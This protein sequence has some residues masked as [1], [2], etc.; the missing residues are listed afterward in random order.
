M[1]RVITSS[2]APGTVLA[3]DPPAQTVVDKGATVSLT[4]AK[5]RPAVPDVTTGN[6]SVADA[7]KTLEDAGYKVD[8]RD[9]ANA[10]P[11]RPSDNSGCAASRKA[12]PMV[13]VPMLP[14]PV[15]VFV[16]PPAAKPLPAQ[17]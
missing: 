11:M 13:S 14:L 12:E 5:E 4:V 15:V 9:D 2:P 16:K 6:P 8:V 17:R 10:P 7:T 3:Q 1:G